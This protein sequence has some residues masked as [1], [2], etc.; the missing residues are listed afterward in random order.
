MAT[1]TIAAVAMLAAL[2]SAITVKPHLDSQCKNAT[3]FTTDTNTKDSIE[4][5]GI[6]DKLWNVEWSLKADF[7]D[8]EPGEGS[9][10]YDIWWHVS[11]LDPGCRFSLLND[12]TQGS[13]G[14]VPGVEVPGNQI[15]NVGNEGCFYSSIPVSQLQPRQHAWAIQAMLTS[16]Y[17]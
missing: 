11:D 4:P 1:R 16:W 13:Y 5:R 8:A 17:H 2:S 6:S 12:Y 3:T 10:A 9:S 15:L 14:M 7:P